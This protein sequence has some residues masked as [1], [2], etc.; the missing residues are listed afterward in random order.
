MNIKVLVQVKIKL[1][2]YQSLCRIFSSSAYSVHRQASPPINRDS[3]CSLNASRCEA[4]KETK[5]YPLTFK[6]LLTT[7]GIAK[8]SLP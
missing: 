1:M 6:A 4:V 5:K 3:F 7:E 2:I 8:R